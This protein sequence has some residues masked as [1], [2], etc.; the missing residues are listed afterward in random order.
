M[1][2]LSFNDET[3]SAAKLT[4]QRVILPS[5]SFND[6]TRTAAKLTAQ[7]V[8]LPSTEDGQRV[9]PRQSIETYN[10]INITPP[11]IGQSNEGVNAP[12]NTSE[13]STDA[14]DED[15]FRKDNP[16]AYVTIGSG[17]V[18]VGILTYFAFQ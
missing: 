15:F 9:V 14:V 13:P 11:T 1:T 8:V 17:I 6:E 3:R 16:L 7:R 4:A 18:V 12:L 5:L 2:S 10:P